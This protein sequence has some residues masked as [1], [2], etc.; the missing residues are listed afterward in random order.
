MVDVDDSPSFTVQ[1]SSSQSFEK[2]LQPALDL[3]TEN[4]E[5]PSSC[6]PHIENLRQGPGQ[7]V[8]DCGKD[9]WMTVAGA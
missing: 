2:E 9:A 1:G 3:P 5:I 4:T 8:Y 7:E 6:C